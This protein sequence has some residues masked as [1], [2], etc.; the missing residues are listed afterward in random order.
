MC[1]GFVLCIL[2]KH[3]KFIELPKD[4]YYFTSLP[5]QLESLDVLLIAAAT[6]VIC[7]LATLY[8]AHQASRLDPVEGIRY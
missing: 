8:P 5:V 4:V 2:L 3:Y 1:L 7:F 6:L